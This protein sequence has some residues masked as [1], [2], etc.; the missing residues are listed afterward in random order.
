MKKIW[1]LKIKKKDKK[2]FY[3]LKKYKKKKNW[4]H[5][6]NKFLFWKLNSHYMKYIF[7]V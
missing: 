6:L 1:I 5:K 7:N 2:K 4:M 3:M